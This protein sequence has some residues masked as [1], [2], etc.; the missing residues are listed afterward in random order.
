MS[1][2]S[3]NLFGSGHHGNGNN[4]ANLRQRCLWF[5]GVIVFIGTIFFF[6]SLLVQLLQWLSEGTADTA[7]MVVPCRTDD[8]AIQYD[9]YALV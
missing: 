2:N 9:N 8:N 1:H 5:M 6:R 3:H 4:L 7:V